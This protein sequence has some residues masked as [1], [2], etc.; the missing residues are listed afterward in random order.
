MEQMV[1]NVS[2][3]SFLIGFLFDFRPDNKH[4][5][6]YVCLVSLMTVCFISI[7]RRQLTSS[8]LLLLGYTG[9][10]CFRAAN[11]AV[12]LPILYTGKATKYKALTYH[13]I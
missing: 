8:I 4:V 2:S 6:S 1:K 13:C 12:I 7:S 3:F 5:L 9:V 11:G 10:Y